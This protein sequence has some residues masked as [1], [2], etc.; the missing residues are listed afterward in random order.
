MNQD[1]RAADFAPP[2]S[3]I[4]L[5]AMHENRFASAKPR[6]KPPEKPSGRR[7]L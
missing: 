7:P 2:D 3:K 1:H 4:T 5:T 6:K